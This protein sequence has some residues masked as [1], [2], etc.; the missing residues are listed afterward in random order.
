[1][2]ERARTHPVFAERIDRLSTQDLRRA[3]K[4]VAELQESRGWKLLSELLEYRRDLLL[5][6]LVHG[7]V[8]SQAEYASQTSMVSG[9]EQ[10]RDAAQT[11]LYV[12]QRR[13]GQQEAA[14]EE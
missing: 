10:M 14:G 9:M 3:A 8:V 2:V 5:T 12:A 7:P 4:D 11:V 1:M 13:E 6:Q